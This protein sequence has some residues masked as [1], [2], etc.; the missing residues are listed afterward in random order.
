[1]YFPNLW[2]FNSKLAVGKEFEDTIQIQNT[3]ET[4]VSASNASAFGALLNETPVEVVD[5]PN[6]YQGKGSLISLSD[7]EVVIS[8]LDKVEKKYQV[9]DS[10]LFFC[11]P[12]TTLVDNVPLTSFDIPFMGISSFQNTSYLNVLNASKVANVQKIKELLTVEN[13]SVHYTIGTPDGYPD[14]SKG[15]VWLRIFLEDCS[16]V[17]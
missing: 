6:D 17:L 4:T 14:L 8:S 11:N 16:N 9:V 13:I 12:K 1:M 2:P 3:P 10:S 7:S 5:K 15:L